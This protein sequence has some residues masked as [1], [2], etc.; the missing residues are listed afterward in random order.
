MNTSHENIY[1]LDPWFIAREYEL[2]KH[3]ALPSKVSKATAING[4][5]QMP[6]FSGGVANQQIVEFAQTPETAFWEIYPELE[7]FETVELE[8][9]MKPP[10]IYWVS[11]IL[12]PFGAFISSKRSGE[13][14]HTE[15]EGWCFSI[16]SNE[17]GVFIRLLS[18]NSF[19]RYNLHLLLAQPLTLGS[20]FRPQ[21]RALLKSHG[22]LAERDKYY[23]ATPLVIVECDE[24]AG[25]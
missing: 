1:Y 11:G 24:H 12:A 8:T 6:V 7:E 9:G 14:A 19:Y 10:N 22:P 2:R 25:E 15:E 20:H 13:Q 4:A 16:G 17:S 23:L 5:F 21:V 3:R 18:E